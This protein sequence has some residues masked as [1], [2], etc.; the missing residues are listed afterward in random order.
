MKTLLRL[1]GLKAC[2]ERRNRRETAGLD[3]K[4]DD[5]RRA[6]E[7]RGRT[8]IVAAVVVVCA[9]AV[10]PATARAADPVT[11]AALLAQVNN[12]VNSALAQSGAADPGRLASSAISAATS[13]APQQAVQPAQPAGVAAIADHAVAAALSATAAAPTAPA[14][15]SKAFDAVSAWPTAHAAPRAA[16][17]RRAARSKQRARR[18]AD[19]PVAVPAVDGFAATPATPP[20]RL[21]TFTPSHV[22]RPKAA[23]RTRSASA[24]AEPQRPPPTPVPPA[25][26]L[27]SAAQGSGGGSV[28]PLVTAA[29]AAALMLFALQF[30]PRA[31]PTTAFRR[32]GRIPLP[33]WHPG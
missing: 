24:G 5:S 33:P 11:A 22:R 12:Q 25:P 28:M 13:A 20:S 21:R 7:P 26:D 14:V 6:R 8:R 3:E 1:D 23:R 15:G 27:G 2:C 29:L 4:L 16:R 9:A 31:L 30:L 17:H 19:R 10:A 32:P 18:H